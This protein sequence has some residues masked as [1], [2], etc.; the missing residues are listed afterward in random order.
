MPAL[1]A[2]PDCNFSRESSQKSGNERRN[3]VASGN[4]SQKTTQ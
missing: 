1:P 3:E 4:V 2:I